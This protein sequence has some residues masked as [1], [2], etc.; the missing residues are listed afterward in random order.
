MKL[1]LAPQEAEPS[2]KLQCDCG[3]EFWVD[4][5]GEEN[6]VFN[7]QCLVAKCPKC[8]KIEDRASSGSEAETKVQDDSRTSANSPK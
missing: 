5:C 1:I 2:V 3:E 4:P 7:G 8:G 6:L